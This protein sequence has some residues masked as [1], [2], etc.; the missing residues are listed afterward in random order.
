MRSRSLKTTLWISLI[1]GLVVMVALSLVADLKET[2]TALAGM[3]H[4]WW[5]ILLGLSLLNYVTRYFKWEYFLRV[6]GVRLDWRDSLG[7]FLGGFVLSVTPGKLGELFKAWLVKEINGAPFSR[8]APVIIAERYTDLAG[9]IVLASAGVYGS[10]FGVNILLIGV[11]L[12]VMLYLMAASKWLRHKIVL[13]MG[14]VPMLAK[15]AASAERAMDSTQ[16]LLRPR[17]L[18]WLTLLSAISWFWECW[19]LGF[20]LNAF[21]G[22]MPLSE[23]VFI[24]SLSTLVGA[25]AFLPGGLGLTEGS[26]ALML[27]NR[28]GLDGGTAMAAT[29]VVRLATLWFAVLLGV[30]ALFIFGR[31]WKLGK[32]L[33]GGGFQDVAKVPADS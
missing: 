12:L 32:R 20:T 30:L 16:E 17:S 14:R 26:M 8:V 33:W 13:L 15:K 29:L 3:S 10:G 28:V 9:L 25:L 11:A 18:P 1:F 21:G 6:L 27:S 5:P 24:Y 2:T 4:M 7:I 31:R 22:T 19:A 23:Q